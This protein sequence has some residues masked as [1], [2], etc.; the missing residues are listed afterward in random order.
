MSLTLDAGT[1]R[2]ALDPV[3]PT[4]DLTAQRLAAWSAVLDR[5]S[6]AQRLVGWRTAHDL[7]HRGILDCWRARALLAGANI[8]ATVDV[9]S[10]A[11]FPGLILAADLPDVPF[12]L[13]EARRKRAAFLREAARAMELTEVVV[14]HGRASEIRSHLGVG[15]ES[16]DPHPLA[17]RSGSRDPDPDPDP[18][19]FASRAFAAP[20]DALTEAHAWNAQ[21]ALVSTSRARIAETPTWPP[22]GWTSLNGNF[23]RDT[24]GDHHEFLRRTRHDRA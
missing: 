1:I 17:R 15:T 23:G 6:R 4:S 11:G 13:V 22:E 16:P 12:H 19:L 14:H 8:G 21:L 18:V 10:G 2:T 5:W 24:S 7:L 9:G 3:H 20:A